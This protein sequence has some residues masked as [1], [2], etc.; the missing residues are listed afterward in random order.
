[1]GFGWDATRDPCD[2]AVRAAVGQL[3]VALRELRRAAASDPAGSAAAGGS[4]DADTR[5]DADLAVHEARKALR[6]ARAMAELLRPLAGADVARDLI[7]AVRGARRRLAEARD[8]AVLP[9]ALRAAWRERVGPGG[10]REGRPP[11]SAVA[12]LRL[13]LEGERGAAPTRV[14]PETVAAIAADLEGA[15]HDLR[16]LHAA[17]RA[18]GGD[19]EPL[20]RGL[21]RMHRRARA[22]GEAARAAVDAAASDAASHDAVARGD[23]DGVAVVRDGAAVVCDGAAVVCDGALHDARKR[24]KE[25]GYVMRWWAPAWRRPIEAWLQEVDALVDVIGAD[26][27]QVILRS[28]LPALEG[29]VDGDLLAR[30]LVA[31]ER[32]SAGLRAKAARNLARLT[33]EPSGAFAARHLAYLASAREWRLRRGPQ[34]RR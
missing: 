17:A 29:A 13:L 22:A 19:L 18:A 5:V 16:L 1:M 25:L 10:V 20:G 7:D 32:R 21:R 3:R 28:R 34:R 24:F 4:I 9:A 2:D 15:R 6:R 26:H 33:A 8:A 23:A 11:G 27:D 14:E 12:P 31:S 30:V